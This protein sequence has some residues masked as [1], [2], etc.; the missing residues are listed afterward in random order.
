M[1]QSALAR[2]ESNAT[3]PRKPT[4]KKSA[5]AMG[6]IVDQLID[7]PGISRHWCRPKKPGG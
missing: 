6:I 4:L 7:K 3:N 2:L 5:E 1:K